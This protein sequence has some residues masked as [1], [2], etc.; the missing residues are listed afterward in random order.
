[1]Q[2]VSKQRLGG[3]TSASPVTSSSIETLF[4]VGCV[5]S[6]HK[7]SECRDRISSGAVT[8]QA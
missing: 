1:V 7:R 8:S 6:A 3:H 4:S 2:P 5:Q